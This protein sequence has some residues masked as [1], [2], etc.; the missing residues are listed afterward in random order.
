MRAPPL[1]A[2]SLIYFFYFFA[3]SF[4]TPVVPLFAT[5][6]GASV[7]DIGLIFA[8]QGAST[9]ILAIPFGTYS[10]TTG[11][12]RMAGAGIALGL[13][14][15][16]ILWLATG[17]VEIA[18]SFL[19]FGISRAMVSP[20]LGAFIADIAGSTKPTRAFGWASLSLQISSTVGPAAG[21]LF[22]SLTDLRA[23]Y[24]VAFSA[25]VVSLL[26]VLLFM[27]EPP[28]MPSAGGARTKQLSGT[29]A[30]RKLQVALLT[31]FVSSFMAQSI[32]SFLPLFANSLGIG[33]GGIGLLFSAQALFSAFSR[34]PIS[35]SADVGKREYWIGPAGIL[36]SALVIEGIGLMHG[37]G[38]LA[39]L[40]A[41][42]GATTGAAN[43]S[44]FALAAKG[45]RPETRG[46]AMGLFE[47]IRYT[48]LPAAGFL[49]AYL[50]DS[51]GYSAGWLGT[52]LVA[53]GVSCATLAFALR[54]ATRRE[55]PKIIS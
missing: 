6:L 51:A 49:T 28:K 40:M 10:D 39:A 34:V 11:R 48:G 16:A 22:A 15:F 5:K 17:V 35:R 21:G 1:L 20:S 29:L 32:T 36:A 41:V 50:I 42:F 23:P 33:V 14:A 55:E 52:G 7:V 43:V 8:L 13:G 26:V 46:L 37:F 45:A 2:V 31:V 18:V 30:S 27:Q 24:A 53:G 3:F 4:V 44:S 38:A 12:K 47:S 25:T 19:L 54:A 9:S